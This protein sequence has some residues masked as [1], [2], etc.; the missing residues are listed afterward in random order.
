MIQSRQTTYML[1]YGALGLPLAFAALPVYV[2]VPRLYAES[3][4]VP[5]GLLGAILFGARLLDAVIDPWLGALADR[6]S[7]PRM[8]VWALPP[9]TLGFIA[10]MSP[11]SAWPVPWL[12]GALL[13]TNL[14]YSGATV[15]YQAWGAQ[16]GVEAEQRTRLTAA[17]E[18]FGLVGVVLAA[19]LPAL[20]DDDLAK[21]LR[22]LAWLLPALLLPTALLTLLGARPA[23]GDGDRPPPADPATRRIHETTRQGARRALHDP[24]FRALLAGFV[25]NGIASALP[26]TLFLFYVAD[27]LRAPATSGPLLALYFIAGAASI[28]F[29]VRAAAALGRVRAWLASMW[30]ATAAFAAAGWLGPGDTAAFAAICLVSGLALGADL[31]LPAALA[32]DHGRRLRAAGACFGLWNLTAKANLALAAGLA[33][34]ALDWLG[35]QPDARVA[36]DGATGEGALRIAYAALPILFKLLA[37]AWVWRRRERLADA[38]RVDESTIPMEAPR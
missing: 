7:R 27:V 19:A 37:I 2:H 23:R 16:I 13:L 38:D 30:L 15:A 22:E 34:P 24:A 31:T 11:S 28:P 1:A 17:R 9:L 18:A 29:W 8:I 21:G 33:L 14:G 25:L 6:V 5:L 36:A 10:L 32:A 4:G 35:Y 20:V 12:I 3:V 26:A